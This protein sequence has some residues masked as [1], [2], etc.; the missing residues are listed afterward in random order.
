LPNFNG[1]GWRVLTGDL[2][3]GIDAV[4][5]AFWAGIARAKAEGR[6]GGR[7]SLVTADIRQA[8]MVQRKAGSS[9]RAIATIVGLS[10][11]TAQKVVVASGAA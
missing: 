6:T 2:R 11:A 4:W 9:I 3:N 1:R 8:I 10:K 5:N 7:P